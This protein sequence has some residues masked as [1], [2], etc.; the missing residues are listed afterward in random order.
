[1]KSQSAIG[2]IIKVLLFIPAFLF[3]VISLTYQGIAL[4]YPNYYSGDFHLF[5]FISY[6]FGAVL[7]GL[8]C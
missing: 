4:I 6:L 7:I 5:L 3:T 2:Q 1:M 8:L